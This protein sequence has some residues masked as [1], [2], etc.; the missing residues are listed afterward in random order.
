MQIDSSHPNFKSN[1]HNVKEP[2]MLNCVPLEDVGVIKEK[3]S[4]NPERLPGNVGLSDI[5]SALSFA[6]EKCI[7]GESSVCVMEMR[8]L[9]VL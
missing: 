6:N 5:A 9:L 2:S 3:M 4:A 8:V 7:K 1:I